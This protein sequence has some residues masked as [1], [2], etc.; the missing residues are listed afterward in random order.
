ML[1]VEQ[2]LYKLVEHELE[3]YHGSIDWKYK[4]NDLPTRI[5]RL[6]EIHNLKSELT[7]DRQREWMSEKALNN[8]DKKSKG[9]FQSKQWNG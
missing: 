8:Y 6:N 5:R 7:L 9:E 3:Y 1:E 2:P 4:E